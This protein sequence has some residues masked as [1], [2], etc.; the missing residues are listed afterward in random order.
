MTHQCLDLLLVLSTQTLMLGL[1][2]T[3][4]RLGVARLLCLFPFPTITTA[5]SSSSI[6]AASAQCPVQPGEVCSRPCRP[7]LCAHPS[8]FRPLAGRYASR[9]DSGP[10]HRACGVSPGGPPG[11]RARPLFCL[12]TATPARRRK[13]SLLG[14]LDPVANKGEAY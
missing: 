11:S 1:G 10:R 14:R 3:A 7:C 6:P 9:E 5:T 12:R 2:F 13:R 4:F 8:R